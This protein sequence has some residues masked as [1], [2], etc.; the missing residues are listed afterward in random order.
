MALRRVACACICAC[1]CSDF[2]PV[3]RL[4]AP[5]TQEF[6]D[7]ASKT[8]MP[9]VIENSISNWS[10]NWDLGRLDAICGDVV[11]TSGTRHNVKSYRKVLEGT[12]WGGLE[13]VDLETTN[14]STLRN[15]TGSIRNGKLS[16]LHDQS[17][18]LWCPAL[19]NHFKMPKYFPVDYQVYPDSNPTASVI[20]TC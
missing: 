7:I 5:S 11:L 14:L 15:L 19:Q 20:F 18:H 2:I 16:Y 1:V 12:T 9:L 17:I 4:S 8:S 13:T 3:R 10:A 6:F